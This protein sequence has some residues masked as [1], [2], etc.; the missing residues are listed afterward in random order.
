M[1]QVLITKMPAYPNRTFVFYNE[2]NIVNQIDIFD[3]DSDNILNNIYIGK[4]KNIASNIE[5]AFVE[6]EDGQL[7]YVP[8]AEL[9]AA[10][11]TNRH[12]GV[13]GRPT[14]PGNPKP[15]PGDEL[16]IQVT[17]E[18]LKTKLPGG[19]GKLSLTG[20]FLVLT[21]GKPML[22]MSGKLSAES[23]DTL[24][25]ELSD[26]VTEEYGFIIRTNAENALISS[27]RAEASRL[28]A[29]YEHIKHLAL[30]RSC[31]TCIYKPENELVSTVRGLSAEHT[32]EIITDDN[33]VKLQIET[34]YNEQP[35]SI[36]IP[37]RLY[38]DPQLS[39]YKLYSL[40][41]T[42]EDALR[43]RVWL[44]S[45]GYL[46]IQPTEALTVIDV[47]TGKFE[48]RK[49]A[50]E[51]FRR[52]N[53]EAAKEVPRQLRLRNISGIII[54]DFIDMKNPEYTQELTACLK[55]ELKNDY[56]KADFVDFTKLG[57]AEITRKKVKKSLKERL[58]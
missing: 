47:N 50:E 1:Q 6:L 15:R 52:I 24:R 12:D 21:T 5:A 48:G 7:C 45:G 49:K 4:I 23:K 25:R 57:L 36:S 43:E 14:P 31:F 44:K 9:K 51:T 39:L 13:N 17:K 18:A 34:F 8:L 41:K 54:I 56:V 16:L 26:L 40:E 28:A 27:I 29:K 37:I 42:M 10:I 55:K 22:G 30:S 53:L 33:S 58:S 2:N 46:I 11:Y 20:T 35:E 38:D 19:T 32:S 3:S